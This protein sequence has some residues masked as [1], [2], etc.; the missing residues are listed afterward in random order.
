MF[1]RL[2]E[3]E[4]VAGQHEVGDLAAAVLGVF[5]QPHDA[6]EHLVGMGGGFAFAENG[7]AF[8]RPDARADVGQRRLIG[9]PGNEAAL[10]CG[11]VGGA[12][13]GCT[14]RN[15][16]N[17]RHGRHPFSLLMSQTGTGAV[18]RKLGIVT[19][20]NNVVFTPIQ[21]LPK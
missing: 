3:A 18:K 19:R 8:A 12:L 11:K 21:V 1:G 6:G 17:H 10:D 14:A 9:G 5:A 2:H 16:Q 15:I 4:I 13:A 7:F 20:C